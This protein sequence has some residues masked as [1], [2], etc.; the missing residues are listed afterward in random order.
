MSYVEYTN[1]L[2]TKMVNTMLNNKTARYDFDDLPEKVKRKLIAKER[3]LQRSKN[4]SEKTKK[5]DNA[6]EDSYGSV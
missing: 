2:K 5:Q 6:S 1:Q 3:D 4:R